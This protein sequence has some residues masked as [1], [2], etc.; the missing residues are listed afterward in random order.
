MVGKTYDHA[1]PDLLAALLLLDGV[2]KNN[3]QE[4]LLIASV[5]ARA[6]LR[7]YPRRVE[8][9]PQSELQGTYIVTA[10]DANN[11]AAPVELDEQPLVKVLRLPVSGAWT[12]RG[13]L[14]CA[15][16]A[17]LL[18]LW[19]CGRHRD[20]FWEGWVVRSWFDVWGL[21]AAR[22][23]NWGDRENTP[24][25]ALSDWWCSRPIR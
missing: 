5:S 7:V 4:D 23:V 3:V 17:N 15:T 16:R 10:E 21:Q 14:I 19:L 24:D 13:R 1:Q 20:Q 12:Q 18:Q 8:G 22:L 11:L 2:V 6:R 25:A 9:R